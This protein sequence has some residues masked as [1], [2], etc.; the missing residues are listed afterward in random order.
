MKEK[1]VF[2]DLQAIKKIISH[3]LLCWKPLNYIPQQNKG[4]KWERRRAEIQKAEMEPEKEAKRI[5]SV[6][7]V[8]TF[9][10]DSCAAGLKT[11]HPDE[12]RRT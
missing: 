5:P 8:E 4:V 10:D 9:Q 7:G 1:N 12:N 6:T 11:S 3:I 2:F